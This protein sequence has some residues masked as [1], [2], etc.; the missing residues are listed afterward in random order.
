[1]TWRDNPRSGHERPDI[2][3]SAGPSNNGEMSFN[4]RFNLRSSG[5]VIFLSQL[6][7]GIECAKNILPLHRAAGIHGPLAIHNVFIP[8]SPLGDRDYFLPDS[9]I[10]PMDKRLGNPSVKITG[11][12]N[13]PGFRTRKLE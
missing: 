12:L 5:I 11:N 13:R 3:S 10:A 1:M 4:P 7:I 2:V 6:Q 8:V 9:G